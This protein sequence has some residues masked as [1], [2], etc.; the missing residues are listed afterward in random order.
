M[1]NDARCD[2]HKPRSFLLIACSQRK[3]ANTEPLPALERYDG[4][5]FRVL[6]K[7]LRAH[8]D[9]SALLEIAILS[10]RFGIIAPSTLIP[11]YDQRL[12]PEQA[13]LLRPEALKILQEYF[14][15]T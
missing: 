2:R 13:L 12:T 11:W 4:P 14:Q 3:R 5:Q 9:A 10:A 1:C 6:R 15:N 7:F 8:P